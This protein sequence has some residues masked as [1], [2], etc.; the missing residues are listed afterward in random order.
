MVLSTKDIKV[1]EALLKSN[2]EDAFPV[3]ADMDDGR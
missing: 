3:E 2:G 1:S